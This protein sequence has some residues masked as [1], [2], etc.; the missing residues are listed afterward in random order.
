[1]QPMWRGSYRSAS[2]L[3]CELSLQLLPPS[4]FAPPPLP[5]DSVTDGGVAVP[6]NYVPSPGDWPCPSP[7]CRNINYARRA[8]CN[9]CGMPKPKGSTA[10]LPPFGAHA[11]GMRGGAAS[12]QQQQQQMG[13]P[14]NPQMMQMQQAQM[15]QQ[16][17]MQQQMRQW[18]GQQDYRRR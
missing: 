1:M 10:A 18:G 4:H 13:W 11:A 17:L 8:A 15:Q 14:M 2:G 9:K 6:R 16:H 7:Q 5:R 12:Q 3:E